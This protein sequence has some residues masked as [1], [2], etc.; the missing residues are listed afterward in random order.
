MAIT[1]DELRAALGPIIKEALAPIIARLDGIDARL[2]GIDE[3]LDGMDARLVS[4]EASTSLSDKARKV[5]AVRLANGLKSLTAPLVRLPFTHNGLPW[6]EDLAPQPA[7]L[8]DLAVSGSEHVPG[9]HAPSGW[10][11]AKSKAFLAKALEGYDEI[12]GS[13]GEGEA[14]AK[15]RTARLKVIAVMG[16][17]VERV[18]GATYSLN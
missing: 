18:I 8:L 5:D 6:T 3:R 4:I 11:R 2:D 14:G 7:R 13:D 9:E 17:N 10:N 12:S 16:G 1:L 15:S